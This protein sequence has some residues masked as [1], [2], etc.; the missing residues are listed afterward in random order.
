MLFASSKIRRRG[1]NMPVD[2]LGELPEPLDGMVR[3]ALTRALDKR[4]QGFVVYISRPHSE[5]I[6]DIREPFRRTLKFNHPQEAEITRELYA[7]VTAIV[8]DE[9]GLNRTT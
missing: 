1:E 9:L 7:T 5:I 6:V 8:E 3:N 2:V 4:P